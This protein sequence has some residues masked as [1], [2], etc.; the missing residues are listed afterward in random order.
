MQR[1]KKKLRETEAELLSPQR[2]YL[3]GKEFQERQDLEAA[4]FWYSK[5]AE[6]KCGDAMLNLGL[7]YQEGLGVDADQNTAV[8]WFE[9]AVEAGNEDARVELARSYETGEGIDQDYVKAAELYQEAYHSGTL[10]VAQNIG[11][12]L[13][14]GN[15]RDNL[16][17]AIAWY[18]KAINAGNEAVY[19]YLLRSKQ[20]NEQ[21]AEELYQKAKS[22]A[23]EENYPEAVEFYEEAAIANH[24]A[25]ANELGKLYQEGVGVTQNDELALFLF[26]K[27]ADLT[28][29][30]AMINLSK[31]Y[32]SGQR[33]QQ[34]VAK[35]VHWCERAK[36]RGVEDVSELLDQCTG[37]R[38]INGDVDE[39][40]SRVH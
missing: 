11:N 3:K 23:L 2:R 7:M 33:T 15:L 1:C 18:E 26:K 21:L 16:N 6:G 12:C 14:F 36:Q 37:K 9:K 10:S 38:N 8:Q 5:A 34:D 20:K 29:T 17:E 24:S 31:C 19:A 35:A 40:R 4:I 13:E 25:A 30:E 27:A 28:N 39:K 32:E 22:L